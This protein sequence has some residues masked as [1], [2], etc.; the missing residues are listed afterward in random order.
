MLKD[1]LLEVL[2]ETQKVNLIAVSKTHPYSAIEEAYNAGQRVF[3]E[4]RVQEI[5]QKFPL[6]ENRPSDMVLILIGH[7][8][9]N[10]VKKAIKLVNRIDSVDSVKLLNEI[11]KE[12]E[13]NDIIMPI[14][15][16]INSSNEE[17]KSGFTN[18]DEFYE[19]ANIAFSNKNIQ[20]QGIMTVGPLTD[21][22]ELIKNAFTFTKNLYYELKDKYNLTVLSM[23]MSS[24]YKIAIEIGSTEVRI[25]SL[26][27]GKRDYS[28]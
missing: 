26:I 7:L 17:N 21:D 23:G 22:E 19:A 6:L 3:G 2:K 13:K 9:T 27:F 24:D 14:L 16:E 18:L 28:V 4:N 15:L 12:A 25:G 10:K 1:N 8:Q 20:F 11:I 5:E